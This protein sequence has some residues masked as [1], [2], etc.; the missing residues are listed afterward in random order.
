M[1]QSVQFQNQQRI[2]TED[3]ATNGHFKKIVSFDLEGSVFGPAALCRHVRELLAC[4]VL[5]PLAA[6]KS[7]PHSLILCQ[8]PGATLLLFPENTDPRC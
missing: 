5:L 1:Y 4:H 8:G 3:Q 7:E 6:W 2:V